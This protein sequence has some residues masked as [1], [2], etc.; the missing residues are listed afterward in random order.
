MFY[1]FCYV[2]CY[3]IMPI[4]LIKSMKNKL[5]QDMQESAQSEPPRNL[6]GLQLPK[7]DSDIV[8]TFHN[9]EQDE[10]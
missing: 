10:L 9:D 4:V 5:K 8:V 2:V 6:E 1:L 7:M 3:N